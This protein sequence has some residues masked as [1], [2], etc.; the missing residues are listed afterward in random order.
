MSEI[1]Q[2]LGLESTCASIDDLVEAFIVAVAILRSS[3]IVLCVV[4]VLI[5]INL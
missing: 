1:S 4:L 5:C 3:G 2:E